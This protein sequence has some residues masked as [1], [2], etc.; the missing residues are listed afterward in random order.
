M[1]RTEL[2]KCLHVESYELGKIINKINSEKPGFF[3]ANLK[4]LSFNVREMTEICRHIPHI[5]ELELQMLVESVFEEPANRRELSRKKLEENDFIERQ[6]KDRSIHV[7][8]NCKCLI[9]RSK[10]GKSSKLYPFCMYF[11][12]YF[13]SMRVNRNGKITKANLYEDNCEEW[14]RGK[15]R[16]WN[17]Q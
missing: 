6:K 17:R 5:S 7:C 4:G 2:A 3:P 12:R 11:D 8:G 1:T 13:S 10:V 16:E 15:P 9:G 14:I